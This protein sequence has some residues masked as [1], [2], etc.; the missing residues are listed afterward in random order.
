M[1]RWS[2][3]VGCAMTLLGTVLIIFF[4]LESKEAVPV[5]ASWLP[6]ADKI[7]HFLAYAA[8]GFSLGLWFRHRP[9]YPGKAITYALILGVSMEFLQPYFQ[10]TRDGGDV[11]ADLLG[12]VAGLCFLA[13]LERLVS[14]TRN[15]TSHFE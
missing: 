6:F 8:L 7:G 9:S 13:L 14:F 12:T 5:V 10:R 15:Q 1:K 2:T 4:S 11:V 3:Y